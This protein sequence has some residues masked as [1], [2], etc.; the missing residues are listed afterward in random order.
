MEL[1]QLAYFVAVAEE[2]QFTRAALRCSVAQPAISAQIRR[3]ERELGESVF[4]RDQRTVSLTAAGEALLPHARAALAAVELGRA[5][6]ASLSGLLHGRLRIGVSRPADRRLAAALGRFHRDHPAIEIVLTE[7]HNAP[8]LQALAGGELDVALVGLPGQPLPPSLHT[9][10]IAAEP[11]VL[12]VRRDHP[13]SS[14][15]SVTLDQLRDEPMITLVHGSGLR[16]VLA[17]ACR[18]AGFTPRITAETSELDSLTELA[19]EGLGIAVLPRSA[20]SHTDLVTVEIRRPRLLRRT[21]LAWNQTDPT[22]AGRAFLAVAQ[23][24]FAAAPPARP[25]RRDGSP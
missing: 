14:R 5:S 23:R 2:A 9:L 4:H 18:D 12:A 17:D 16:A 19:T 20:S 25:R 1:R 3:L 13:L 21:A 11:L 7:Q 15:K 24:S 10:V 6:V 8:L 22:P